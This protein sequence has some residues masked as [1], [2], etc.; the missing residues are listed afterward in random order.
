MK[1]FA[2]RAKESWYS[3]AEDK[4]INRVLST[5]LLRDCKLLKS[6]Q[7]IHFKYTV[8]LNKVCDQCLSFKMNHVLIQF[9]SLKMSL[10]RCLS[11]VFIVHYQQQRSS[12]TSHKQD[13]N[14]QLMLLSH[15]F[16][17]LV[18]FLD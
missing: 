5:L 16:L 3:E 13:V 1:C 11:T 6:R 7:I 17:S 18:P 9:T 12:H 10:K 2:V 15:F 14:G 4:S 8:L